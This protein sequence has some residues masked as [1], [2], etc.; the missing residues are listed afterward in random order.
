MSKPRKSKRYEYNL[1]SVLKVRL[2]HEKQ[3]QDKFTEAVRRVEKEQKKEKELIDLQ[4]ASYLKLREL[5]SGVMTNLNEI[6]LR[7][8][9]LD[10]LKEKIIEQKEAVK[11]AEEK[12]EEQRL[13]LI[14]ATMDKKIIEKDKEKKKLAWKKLMEKEDNKFLD[15]ISS[16]GFEMKRRTRLSETPENDNKE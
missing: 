8:H 5:M 10:V 11:Q 2:I 16:I 12:K 13:A 1:K 6:T 7:K 9:H 14:K 3:E 15:D 4:Q